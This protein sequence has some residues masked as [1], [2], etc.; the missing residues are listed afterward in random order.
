M[1]TPHSATGLSL[2]DGSD[3]L[4]SSGPT[5]YHD[6]FKKQ[7]RLAAATRHCQKFALADSLYSRNVKGPDK[8]IPITVTHITGPVSYQVQ[9]TSGTFTLINFNIS[10]PSTVMIKSPITL[11][12]GLFMLYTNY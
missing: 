11:M 7:E 12:I 6:D 3:T 5:S 4:N 10:I 1:V 9:A 2:V 8:W